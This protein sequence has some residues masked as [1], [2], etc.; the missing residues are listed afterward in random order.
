M[1]CSF[2]S[3]EIVPDDSDSEDDEPEKAEAPKDLAGATRRITALQ[4]K[5]EQAKQD[6]VYYRGFVSQRLNLAGLADEL[7][8]SAV[9]STTHAAVPLRD[10][11]SQY[12]QSYAENGQLCVIRR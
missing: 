7:K 9:S 11:D 12:F 5:L 2:V 1:I 8:D 10:D 4:R 6:L 3:S